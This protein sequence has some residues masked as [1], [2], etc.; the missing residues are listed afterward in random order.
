MV[1][2]SPCSL[3]DSFQRILFHFLEGPIIFEFKLPLLRLSGICKEA[4]TIEFGVLPISSKI[5]PNPF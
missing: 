5:F 3:F 2:L 1:V 4:F